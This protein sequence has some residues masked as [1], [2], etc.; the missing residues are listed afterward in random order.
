MNAKAAKLSPAMIACLQS[1]ANPTGSCRG[2]NGAKWT[3][4]T[5]KALEARELLV[6]TET[7]EGF[8]RYTLT[9]M[10][11]LELDLATGDWEEAPEGE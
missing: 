7:P 11:R 9:G 10:G 8:G 1:K 5:L 4:A 2:V 3:G 6:R